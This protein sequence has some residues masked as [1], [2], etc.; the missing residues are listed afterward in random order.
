MNTVA[1]SVGDL[2]ADLLPGLYKIR[3]R[4]GPG[5]EEKLISLD[6]DLFVDIQPPPIFSPIPLA[7]TTRSHEY[8][9]LR[10]M[11]A[12]RSPLHDFGQGAGLFVFCREWTT[13]NQGASPNPATGISLADE[14][15]N[16]LLDLGSLAVETPNDHS[17]AMCAT[18]APG[19]YRLRLTQSGG[20]V[21]ERALFASPGCQTQI[22]I[23]LSPP[24]WSSGPSL[25]D[26]AGGAVIISPKFEFDPQ[27]RR[28]QLG[29]IARYAL[30]QKRRVLS[31]QLR[32]EI[33]DEKFDDPMLGL[34]GA[35]LVLRDEP[36]NVELF[37]TVT[38]NLLRLLGPDHPDLRALCLRRKNP[39]PSVPRAL[40]TPPM[41]R[42]SW[43]ITVSVSLE[44]PSSFPEAGGVMEIADKVIPTGS[45]LVWRRDP[46]VKSASGSSAG[47]SN[48]LA[49]SLEEF[50]AA[51]ARQEAS[52]R[53]DDQGVFGRLSSSLFDLISNSFDKLRG[54]PQPKPP[55]PTLSTEDREELARVLGIPG[56][57]LNSVLKKIFD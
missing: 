48:A 11:N 3:V 55:M 54:K 24:T 46:I 4:N 8:H 47:S 1:H 2:S 42:A 22:F 40:D 16:Q 36:E 32:L 38:N 31:D 14:N 50:I 28:T 52:R 30:T 51:R 35:H 49:Q 26:I 6:R 7:G 44:D 37:E 53:A 5:V 56:P 12:S 39:L 9:M 41:L 23:L 34:L 25:P 15:G 17:V 45:W 21:T 18:V 43:D 13:S 19:S 29:E 57:L 33:V 27:D 20:T 10:A